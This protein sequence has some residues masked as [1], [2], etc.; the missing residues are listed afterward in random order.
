MRVTRFCSTVVVN[1][2][3]EELNVWAARWPGSRLGG[4]RGVSIE[5]DAKNGDLVGGSV[6]TL[7]GRGVS[8]DE[9]NALIDEAKAFAF[10][11]EA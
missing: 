6:T 1:V 8:G 7:E 4:R 3:A 2:S 11:K 9:L 10:T 5:F